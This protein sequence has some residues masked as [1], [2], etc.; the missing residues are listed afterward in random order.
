MASSIYPKAKESFLSGDIDLTADTIKVVL[1]DTADET[2]N[3]ADQFLS[4]ITAGGIVGTAVTLTSKTVTNGVFD[5]ADAT[6]TG[7]SGDGVEVA[8]IYKDT[9]S[10]ATSNLIAWVELPG[11]VTPVGGDITIQWDS[12]ANKIFAL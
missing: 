11:T 12:G 6:L 8:L 9:G 3:S 10:S 4:S 5:A 7:V 1:I 2:Y